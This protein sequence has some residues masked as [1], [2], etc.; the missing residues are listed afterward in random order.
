MIVILFR[1]AFGKHLFRFLFGKILYDAGRVSCDHTVSLRKLLCDHGTCP[2]DRMWP[3][4]DAWKD[5][6]VRAYPTML[7][8][9]DVFGRHM[10]IWILH[11]MIRRDDA[12]IGCDPAPISNIDVSIAP[13]LIMVAHALEIVDVVRMKMDVLIIPNDDMRG[14]RPGHIGV[15]PSPQRIDTYPTPSGCSDPAKVSLEPL[16]IVILPFIKQETISD[17]FESL[18]KFD[19]IILGFDAKD[20]SQAYGRLFT[21]K[22]LMVGQCGKLFAIKEFRELPREKPHLCNSGIMVGNQGVLPYRY[23]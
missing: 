10:F 22:E 18:G 7:A 1:L 16:S 17:M 12:H 9:D 13:R 6:A 21:D 4:L 20:Q 3:Q 14:A 15:E 2:H 11:G 5:H 23:C 19:L 8:K